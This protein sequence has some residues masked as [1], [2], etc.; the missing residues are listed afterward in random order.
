MINCFQRF[1]RAKDGSVAVE[2][3]MIALPF[4]LLLTG[5]VEVAVLYGSSIVL[6]GATADAA[7]LVRTGQAQAAA[8]PET[9][10]RDQL[11][12]HVASF[13]P[14]PEIQYEAIHM[15]GD[16]FDSFEDYA[17][18]YDAD[19][20]FVPQGFDTGGSDS[21]VLIRVV[22]RYT[23]LTPLLG[24]IMSGGGQGRVTL[25]STAVIKNEPFEF[26]S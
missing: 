13:I 9:A 20:N 19:G 5:I 4:T 18:Q 21:V 15:A 23:Y 11:C 1:F 16:D 3:A 2:F 26:G 24:A 10:F 22:H 14:C 12:Q 8:D 25:M 6:E 17:P 7:R